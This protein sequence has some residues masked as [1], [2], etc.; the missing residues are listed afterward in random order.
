[1]RPTGLTAP[2]ACLA[3]C[4]FPQAGSTVSSPSPCRVAAE[5]AAAETGV[6]LALLLAVAATE[7]GRRSAGG[8][9]EPWPWAVNRA[10]K[11]RYPPDR[12]AA[13]TLVAEAL[14]NGERN[15]DI[16]CFQLNWHWHGAAF[17]SAAAMFDPLANARHAA[18]FLADLHAE[19][20]DWRAAAGAYHSRDPD[21][22]A[23]YVE[24]LI[25]AHAARTA[26]PAAAPAAAQPVAARPAAAGIPGR[27]RGPLLDGRGARGPL[28][29]A[30]P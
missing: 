14:A 13:E 26:Q 20:G 12:E 2:A 18:R 21:R 29:G 24:R 10:G 28:I 23:A 27:A 4:L 1:M 6:P 19:T 25:A 15:I 16:G 7:S 17:P 30:R 9:A 5:T 22:A 3:L 11:G 8:A